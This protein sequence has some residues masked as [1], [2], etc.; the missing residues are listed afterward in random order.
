MVDITHK[1]TSLRTAIAEAIV[2]V[3][4]KETIEAILQDKVPKGNVFEMAKTAGLFAV[5][6]TSDMIPDCHPLPVE[7]T[8][9]QYDI[10]DLR[11]HIRMEVR[12]IYRT[13][14]EVEAM[15]GVSVV[16][17]TLYDMLKPIDKGIEIQ[18]IRLVQKTGG[19]SD[20]KGKISEKVQIAYIQCSDA[21]YHKKKT[22]KLSPI[23][24]NVL[25]KYQ[26][27]TQVTDC[28]PDDADRIV[29][30]LHKYGN[31][32]LILLTGGTG[33]TKNDKVPEVLRP[34]LDKEIPGI[35]EAIRQFGNDRTAK[36]IMSGCLGGII[37]GTLVIALP[38]SSAG[39][40]DALDAVFPFVLTIV[41]KINAQK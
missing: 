25:S 26:L 16:A 33:L 37:N 20:Y 29:E 12:A 10:Q 41:D 9:V 36:A 13:G 24:E 17:L 15:H 21:L 5:K 30:S 31:H 38:G 18:N 23:L 7:F 35:G 22:D 8:Q 39:L 3:S 11:I 1:R 19:K 6:R 27:K 40:K 14:V 4:K 34:L 28:I 32:G 2:A